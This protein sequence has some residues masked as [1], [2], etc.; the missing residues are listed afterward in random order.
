MSA[1]WRLRAAV[2]IL[3]ASLAVHE[4]RYLFATS[5]HEHGLAG[6]HAYLA[7]LI[8]AAGALLFLAA[9]HL[10]VRLPLS[11]PGPDP[12]LPRLR[13]LWLVA[14]A[15]LLHVFAL[16]ELLETALSHGHLPGPGDLLGGG[17]WTAIPFAVAA[18]AAV[19][20]LLRGAAG[21]VRWA[22]VR[23]ARRRR[24]PACAAHAPATPLPAPRGSVL[25]RRLA[26]RGPPALV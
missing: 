20:L 19:A 13:T 22:L 15:A 2:L 12:A 16:Q 18:A 23:A 7:W 9:A 10:A 21:I 3:V 14:T 1:L 25:A 5:D 24:V 26:G 8:P 6:A 11:E 4:G 17:G